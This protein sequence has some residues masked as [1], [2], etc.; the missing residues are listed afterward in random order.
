[1][2]WFNCLISKDA[3]GRYTDASRGAPT[4]DAFPAIFVAADCFKVIIQFNFSYFLFFYC[5][6][7]AETSKEGLLDHLPPGLEFDLVSCQFALHYSFSSETKVRGMLANVSGRL[8]PGGVFLGT[9]PNA[10]VIV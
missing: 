4:S 1:M 7:N 5:L 6:I 2:I 10:N 3:V 9:I 8:K